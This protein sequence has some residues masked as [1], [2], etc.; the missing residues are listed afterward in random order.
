MKLVTYNAQPLDEFFRQRVP[1]GLINPLLKKLDVLQTFGR[2]CIQAFV[3]PKDDVFHFVVEEP[4]IND[5]AD[6]YIS[7]IDINNLIIIIDVF[8]YKK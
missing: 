1:Q 5:V 7:F 8:T 2:E 3:F 6:V 4:N